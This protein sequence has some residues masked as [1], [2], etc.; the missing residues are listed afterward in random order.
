MSDDL[1]RFSSTFGIKVQRYVRANGYHGWIEGSWLSWYD[2]HLAHGVSTPT[3]LTH[4]FAHWIVAPKRRK[5]VPHFGLGGPHDSLWVSLKTAYREEEQASLLGICL[6]VRLGYPKI[7]R[8]DFIEHG[9]DIGGSFP[10]SKT[11]NKLRKNGLISPREVH[12]VVRTYRDLALDSP[13]TFW[14]KKNPL[15]MDALT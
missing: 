7:A 5:D 4:E 1:N 12:W 10:L 9:W 3:E 2:R 14:W 8:G 15:N 6:T 13:T 11:L